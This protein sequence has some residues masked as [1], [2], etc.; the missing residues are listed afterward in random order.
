MYKFQPEKLPE[1][2]TTS[3]PLNFNY[4]IPKDHLLLDI[5]YEHNR[6]I[7]SYHSHDSLLENKLD[8]GLTAE[9]RRRG[10]Y[11]ISLVY[12]IFRFF[13]CCNLA[14]EEYENLKRMPDPRQLAMERFQQQQRLN[15]YIAQQNST[16][17][18]QQIRPN[19]YQ[20]FQGNHAQYNQFNQIFHQ[21]QSMGLLHG[22]TNNNI[23]PTG[24][25]N[26]IK[27]FNKKNFILVPIQPRTTTSNDPIIV[28]SDDDHRMSK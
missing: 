12:S 22:V 18:L 27:N 14:L 13:C 9:E 24:Y 17:Q 23:R 3:T 10:L 19:V 2:E 1:A 5:L 21:L 25:S 28:E 26:K 4:A 8:E 15:N 6:W 7:H 20:P 11:Y 16:A